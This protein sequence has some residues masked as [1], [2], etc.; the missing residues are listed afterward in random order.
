MDQLPYR[1]LFGISGISPQ[2][3]GKYDFASGS[4]LAL[5]NT[6]FVGGFY[7]EKMETGGNT[8]MLEIAVNNEKAD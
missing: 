4:Q 6:V 7:K 2:P 5:S 8:N 3:L 1:S